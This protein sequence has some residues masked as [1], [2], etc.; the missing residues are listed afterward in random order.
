MARNKAIVV[1]INQY[2]FLQ[3]LS[4]AKRDAELMRHFLMERAG[5]E[6]VF[7]FTD[8]SPPEGGKPTEPFRS[9]LERILRQTAQQPSLAEGSNFWFFFSGHGMRHENRDYLMPLDGDPEDVARSGIATQEITDRLRRCGADNIVMI[10]DACRNQSR[11]S[12]EG[13][14]RQTEAEARRTGVIS[15]FSCSPEQYSYELESIGQGA[16]T[17]ALLEGL[18]VRGRCATI[19]RL[20]QYLQRRVPDL[21]R[22]VYPNAQQNPYLI[23][24]PL[25]R[26]HLILMP[27]YANLAEIATLKNDA[28]KA[29]TRRDWKRAKQL[30]IQ[31]L[32]AASGQ[33][34]DAIEAFERIALQSGISPPSSAEST[35]T[36]P[37]KAVSQLPPSRGAVH[38]GNS[39]FSS[40]NPSFESQIPENLTVP[41]PIQVF[42]YPSVST[43]LESSIFKF[44]IINV[45]QRGIEIERHK[46][47]AHFYSES[48]NDVPLEMVFIPGG[49]FLMGL[50]ENERG[51]S[52]EKPQHWVTVQSFLMSKHPI[53]QAQWKAV[54][55]SSSMVQRKLK[56]P[57]VSRKSADKPMTEI[58]W[59]DAVE[60]CDRLSGVVNRDY[61]LP[62]EAEWEYGC[63]AGSLTPFHFGETIAPHLANYDCS[64]YSYA[65]AA[66]GTPH[67]QTT[68][69][70]HFPFANAFGLF[71]MH[72][73]IWE[74]CQDS[75]HDNY[76]KAPTDG[77][78]WLSNDQSH[79]RVMRGG[80]WYNSPGDCR[81]A[82]R[83]SWDAQESLDRIGFRIVC[84]EASIY[85]SSSTSSS[86]QDGM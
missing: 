59:Y 17:A 36:P 13:I 68:P 44:E 35:A 63:R 30:W 43:N 7:L 52:N 48:I 71:D 49:K 21:V 70:N 34:M 26:T 2:R 56:S 4:Y 29:E 80:S 20:N 41:S 19:E 23:A 22:Q 81:S 64:K 75:W 57:R 3:Q 69:V 86:S 72:G 38:S 10:L 47:Q 16:F 12:G 82:Y 83:S 15:I 24:E 85:S 74:W 66:K 18:D 50:P 14:G 1:G 39:F 28:Y 84:S 61:R 8:D 27:Q 55:G 53:T 9:N 65:L 37:S 76:A 42:T 78:A 40:A 73:N 62:T 77:S 67:N 5:F 58:S 25:E 54:V 31:V 79:D 6:Q 32:A 11:K 33:D 51:R 45:D 46:R 60:F